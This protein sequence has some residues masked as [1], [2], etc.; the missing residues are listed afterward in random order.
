VGNHEYQTAGAPG[1]YG[2]FGAA[3][4]DPAKG[5]YS[6]NM[7]AWHV[8][9][10]NSNC[11]IVSCAA[12]STQEQWLRADLAANPT[13]CTLAYW[14]HPRFSSGGHGNDTTVAPFWQAL[15]DTN[16]DLVLNGHEHEYERFAPQ[17]PSA[18]ADTA[19]GIRELIVG[20]GGKNETAFGTVQ[21]NSEVRMTGTFGV[22]KLTLRATG[23]DWQ[24]LPEAGK[25]FTDS[26][27]GVCH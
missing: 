6:Y 24:F 9:V 14:H 17:N 11:T 21:A 15:Y 13:T 25:T 26:G 23:Y 12:G 8:V 18:V 2:Y 27:S 7:G 5:Y 20:T 16:A 22:L 10:L 1:Y 4:G 3:A 19:R